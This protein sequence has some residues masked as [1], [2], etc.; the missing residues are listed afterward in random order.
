MYESL[1]LDKIICFAEDKLKDFD[2]IHGIKHMATVAKH[3]EILAEREKA[4]KKLCIIAAYLHDIGRSKKWVKETIDNNHGIKSAKIAE[5]FLL[6]N[7]LK[8]FEVKEI[9]QAISSHCFPEIQSTPTSKILWD[10]DKLCHFSREMEKDYFDYWLVK[11]G[12]RD[13][14]VKKMQ[15]EREFYIKYFNTKTAKEIA[16][17]MMKEWGVK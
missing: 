5:K 13:K 17:T 12:D 1:E 16:M 10:A 3:A 14:A 9:C 11:F 7:S 8:E 6:S 15:G 4:N 2:N